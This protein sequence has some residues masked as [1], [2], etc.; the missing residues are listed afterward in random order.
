MSTNR[1]GHDSVLRRLAVILVPSFGQ[2]DSRPRTSTHDYVACRYRWYLIVD[3]QILICVHQVLVV[4]EDE[5]HV[6]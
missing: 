2:F 3:D 4:L 5:M 1:L 6:S